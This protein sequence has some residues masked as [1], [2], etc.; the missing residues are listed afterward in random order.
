MV[1]RAYPTAT[2]EK[3]L[4]QCFGN[5]RWVWNEALAVQR[6][7]LDAK[8][9][10][11]WRTALSRW[12]TGWKQEREWLALC[13]ASVMQQ[14]LRDLGRAWTRCFTRQARP[15][16]FKSRHRRQ[17]FR[18]TV[19]ARHTARAARWAEEQWAT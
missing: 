10:M 5:R 12:L 18:V 16:R 15:P 9:L 13:P 6:K 11:P 14:A 4:A 2:Q 8:Q 19:D 17:S 3:I 1:L 7:A